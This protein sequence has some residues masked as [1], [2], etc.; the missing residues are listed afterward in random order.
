MKK[1]IIFIFMLFS[2]A[3]ILAQSSADLKKQGYIAIQNKNFAEAETY[4][5]KAAE[6]TPEDFQIWIV[7]GFVQLEQKK[8]KETLANLQQ[9]YKI[10]PRQKQ[11]N[12]ARFFLA[13]YYLTQNDNATA[14]KYAAEMAQYGAGQNYV[15]QFDRDAGFETIKNDPKFLE[16]KEQMKKN[17]TPCMYDSNFQV[18]DFW[19]GVWD[20]YVKGNY[21]DYKV[22][23]A[24][25]SVVR[26]PGGCSLIEFF[27]MT[28][29]SKY[30]GRSFSF[31]DD[32]KKVYRHQWTGSQG[33]IINYE[34]VESKNNRYVMMATTTIPG[35]SGST[36]LRRMTMDYDP[37][38]RT[39]HQ[40]IENS[41]NDGKTWEVEW[42]ALFRKIKDLE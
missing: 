23:V 26:S 34:V 39:L 12:D 13:K 36:R 1:I 42:D 33:D 14:I 8:Y 27:D 37:S 5:K 35:E 32:V 30:F 3:M 24:V 38:E 21:P 18:L 11:K 25:D 40:Y 22:K 41:Y 6:I 17:A 31:Y 7:L 29:Q 28:P 19:V 9:S 16:I 15:N 10:A 4:F 2:A 20:V